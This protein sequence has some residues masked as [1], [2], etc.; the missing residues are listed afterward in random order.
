MCFPSLDAGVCDPSQTSVEPLGRWVFSPFFDSL[1]GRY[2]SSPT[3]LR[4]VDVVDHEWL[5]CAQRN[6]VS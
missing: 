3:F 1:M 5:P 6:V 2:P 4:E